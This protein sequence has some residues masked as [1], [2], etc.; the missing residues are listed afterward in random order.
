[1][2]E[3]VVKNC[4]SCPFA[5]LDNEYGHACQHP[6]NFDAVSAKDGLMYLW[7]PSDKVHDFCPLKQGSITV[8]IG[9]NE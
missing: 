9:C 3:F 8:K 7:L 6:F 5:D 2:N 4:H 1:M